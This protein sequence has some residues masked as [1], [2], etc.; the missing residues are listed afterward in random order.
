MFRIVFFLGHHFLKRFYFVFWGTSLNSVYL[1][2]F[3]LFQYFSK[4]DFLFRRLMKT[5]TQ[6]HYCSLLQYFWNIFP[7]FVEI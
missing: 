3:F 6:N 5:S 7:I 1:L 2:S 4:Y